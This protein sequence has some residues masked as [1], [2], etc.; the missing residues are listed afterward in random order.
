MKTDPR[1]VWYDQLSCFGFLNG[2]QG[3]VETPS[4]RY[5]IISCYKHRPCNWLIIFGFA[6][7]INDLEAV[8]AFVVCPA[9]T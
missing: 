8:L 3:V 1:I 4:F 5:H 6:F 2:I 7:L 9:V